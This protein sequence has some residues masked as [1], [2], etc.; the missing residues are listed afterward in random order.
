MKY[1]KPLS[2][3]ILI[4]NCPIQHLDT[5]WI[6]NNVTLVQQDTVLFNETILQNI[7]LGNRDT[8]GPE[9]VKKACE[10]ACLRETIEEMPDG[11]NT[12][13]G[14]GGRSLS[15]GQ[16]QRVAIARARLRDAPILILDEATSALDHTSRRQVMAQIREWRKGKTTIIITHDLSPISD[17]DYV[18]V[19]DHARVVQEGYRRKWGGQL[20]GTLSPIPGSGDGVDG[21]QLPK[22]SDSTSPTQPLEEEDFS[23]RWRYISRVFSTSNTS[24]NHLSWGIGASEANTLRSSLIWTNHLVAN[25]PP[26]GNSRRQSRISFLLPIHTP[27]IPSPA[28]LEKDIKSLRVPALSFVDSSPESRNRS[29]ASDTGEINP[30][31]PASP[32]VQPEQLSSDNIPEQNYQHEQKTSPVSLTDIF[33]TV[34]PVLTRKGRIIFLFGFVAA[35]L[36]AACTPTFAYVF[37]RL[38]GVFY[39]PRDERA[40][41][42]TKWALSL[43]GIATVDGL[44]CFTTHYLLEYTGQSWITL[45]RLEALKR[46]LSQPKSWFD[47]ENNSPSQ[48]SQCLDRNAEEMRNLVGRFAGLVF[49]VIWMLGITVV[50]AF[51]IS[52]KLTLVALGCAPVVYLI[53]RMFHIVS[54]K[55]EDRCN[56][57]A[58]YTSSIFTETFSNIRVVRAFTLENYF[59]RKHRAAVVDTYKTGISRAMYTGSLYGASDAVNFFITALVFYYGTVLITSGSHSVDS[60]IQVVNILLFGISNA[61]NMLSMVP[62][63]SSSC[64]TATAMLRLTNLPLDPSHETRGTRRLATPL[65][66]EMTSLSFTYPKQSPAKTLSQVSLRI[67][68]GTCTAIVGPS[69]SGKS[70]LLSILQCLYPPD[71]SPVLISPAALIFAGIPVETCSVTN[72]RTHISIV[73][74]TPLLFPSSILANITYG[75]PETSPFRSLSAAQRAAE[76]V[77]IHSFVNSL[78]AG[79]ETLIG[80]G[81]MGLSGGQAQ[82]IA[83]ARALIRRPKVLILDEA[84]SALDGENVEGVRRLVR[85]L[86]TEGMA[87]VVVSHAVEMMRLADWVVVVEEGRV[88]EEGR[89]EE[90]CER[91]GALAKL[92]GI[93]GRRRRR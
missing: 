44:A 61:S 73:P 80:D 82:R 55:W 12:V 78:D 69:G 16:K 7:S 27:R 23:H 41:Q 85:G 77:G 32:Y 54:S 2:G 39:L 30:R 29:L 40:G 45:L 75:L 64:T 51:I 24:T 13:V 50:C 5:D 42:A 66:I 8:C 18:Y 93:E 70:T 56:K 9:D 74:Q 88:T 43:L 68:A 48:L 62:Q 65:P 11:L 19:L 28:L 63:I 57:R 72:L 17:S 36:V 92:I 38:L 86:V 25:S 35:F 49:T 91:R 84:T 87:V 89:F 53:T 1:Y 83:I 81:G 60:I 6:R 3:E 31:S 20:R 47:E 22:T 59:A 10:A 46:I 14:L 15:G 90:L 71:P 79:Y 34:W 67:I 37:A 33:S 21:K 76:Q 58:E 4:D 52:R 26:A